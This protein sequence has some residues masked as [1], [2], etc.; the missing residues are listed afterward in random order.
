VLMIGL[1][2]ILEWERLLLSGRSGYAEMIMCNDKS[3]SLL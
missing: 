1:K 2:N 3:T